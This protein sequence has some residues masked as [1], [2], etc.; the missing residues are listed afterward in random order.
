MPFRSR[1]FTFYSLMTSVTLASVA[2]VPAVAQEQEVTQAGTTGEDIVITGTALQNREAIAERRG[3]STIVDTLI[4][5]DTGDLADQS[6]SEALARVPGVSTM[7]VLYG[8][9]ESQY[10]AVRGIT[11]D[12]NY[13][14]LDGIGMISVANGGAGQRRVDLALI[15]SQAARQTQVFKTFT[16]DQDAGAVGG[17]I[18]IVPHSAFAGRERFFID[19]FATYTTADHVPGDNSLGGYNDTPWGGG[20]KGLLTK[21][22]G[23]DEQFG[24]VLSG[25]FTQRTYDETK[26]NPN[27]RAYYTATGA[28]TT[29][30][31]PN[32][33]GY[34]PSPTAFVSY[35]F[36]S[37]VRTYGGTAAF[38]YRPSSDWYASLLV[39]DYV[40]TED[41]T[42]PI[43]NLRGFTG[44]TNHTPTTGTL[45]VPD[46]RTTYKY[47]RFENESRGVLLKAEHQM[48][49]GSS[50]AFRAGYNDNSFYNAENEA[51]YRQQP[52]NLFVT[53]D[54]SERSHRFTLSDPAILMD[55]SRYSL[56]TAGDTLYE[57]MGRSYEARLDFRR[58]VDNDSAGFGYQA[59]VGLRHFDLERDV[60]AVNY[61]TDRS[62]LTPVAL[63]PHFVPQRFGYNVLW[64]DYAGF[65]QT[66]KPNLAINQT[67]SRNDSLDADYD[68]GETITYGYLN[69]TYATERT[70]V[71]GGLRMDIAD[72]DAETPLV[73]GGVYQQGRKRSGGDYG[74]LLPSLNLVHGFTDDLRLKA[75]Y[76]RTLGRPAPEDIARPET[77]NDTSFT[78]SRGNPDLKP[79][80]SDNFDVALE[81]YFNGSSGLFSVGG[82]VKNI[83]DDIYDLKEE[84][85]IDGFAY[86]I[87]TP[88]NANESQ[89]RGIEVQLINNSLGFLPG[90]LKNKVGVAL[91]G[92]R[93]WGSMDYVVGD[94]TLHIDRLLYQREWLANAALFYKLPRGGELRVAYSYGDG[95]YDGIGASPWLH[96]G[97]EGRGQLDMTAR[98]SLAD[99][100]IVKF[101]AKNL[102][103][104]DIYLGY[105]DELA[106]RR[107]EMNRGRQF[108]VNLIYRP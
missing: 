56:L 71:I 108:F 48:R 54:A 102:L 74:F 17:I 28:A 47:D 104:E 65:A 53:Y 100:W 16:A 2:A 12:L 29:P 21:R 36:T 51:T 19:A 97:P 50:M 27:G 58:N 57:A 70:R 82:F 45:R 46:V 24:L 77:R 69:T 67:T 87:T 78:I 30:D 13:V 25:T 59:G 105:G 76:S 93:I 37:F 31:N 62:L 20:I 61:V 84:Q 38:E 18:N 3:S 26:R 14:S 75:A 79:R 44:I 60:T 95:Y 81:Y 89:M 98:I 92:T 6:L 96:R 85:V 49:D 5:D 66:V 1:R 52:G 72:Y 15:P 22:F 88:M 94:T 101:Q 32:W 10:V 106:Y 103:D 9:Q 68:Y 86:T 64:I 63:D 41:Q 90:F 99:A 55:A 35:D 83:K 23:A 11:P 7:Q 39:Y 8:E 91:N 4:Q 33:N 42:D 80:R 34:E 73:V 107:A 43:F 40:Q